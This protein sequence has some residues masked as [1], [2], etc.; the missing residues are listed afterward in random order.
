MKNC[1]KH[2][3]IATLILGGLLALYELTCV[4]GTPLAMAL[5]VLG[6]SVVLLSLSVLLRGPENERR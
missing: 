1:S 5:A 3:A 4:H 6:A 2:L